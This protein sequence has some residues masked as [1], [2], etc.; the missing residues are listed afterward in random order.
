MNRVYIILFKVDSFGNFL[1]AFLH[2][3]LFL[4]RVFSKSRPLF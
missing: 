2:T 3:K 1:L 4:Q